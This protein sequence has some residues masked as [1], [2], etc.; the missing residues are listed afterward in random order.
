[1]K[2]KIAQPWQ[3]LEQN[4]VLCSLARSRHVNFTLNSFTG[5]NCFLETTNCS[6]IYERIRDKRLEMC[7]YIKFMQ[8]IYTSCSVTFSLRIC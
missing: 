2:N 5:A 6:G 8:N 4:Y 3:G 1:M 7:C